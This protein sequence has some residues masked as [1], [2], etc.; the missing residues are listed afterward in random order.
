[1]IPLLR[2]PKTVFTPRGEAVTE[3]YVARPALE[4]AFRRG[5]DSPKNIILHGESGSGKTWLY[6][7]LF[8]TDSVVF[9][10]ANLGRAVPLGSIAALL[11][12]VMAREI[13]QVKTGY[14]TEKETGVDAVIANGRISQTNDFS[15]PQ[16]DVFEQALE[17]I[18]TGAGKKRAALVF[19][20][21]EHILDSEPLL[22]ELSS[23]L[24]L[25]DDENYSKYNVKTVLVSTASNVRSYL[26]NTEKSNTITN[27]I[28]EVPEV[29]RLTQV[30]AR[31]FVKKG[32]FSLLGFTISGSS[33]ADQNSIVEQIIW[34]TDRIPQYL[35]ELCLELAITGESA[36][37]IITDEHLMDA[38]VTWVRSSLISELSVVEANLNS[39]ATTIGRKNQVVYALGQCSELEFDH[40]KIEQ[41]VRREFPESCKS[42]ALNVSQTLAQLAES[43]HPIIRRL[44]YGNGYRFVDPKLRIVVRWKLKKEDNSERLTLRSFDDAI[45]WGNSH[46]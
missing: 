17:W 20:N 4:D 31:E 3:M 33:K 36:G 2:Q 16:R 28:Y 29:A 43:D 26:V 35:H 6:K 18:R 1:M 25:V 24:L 14:S 38:V 46:F 39:K 11:S 44:P 22:R 12:S 7:K 21:L 41:V 10:V 34:Y 30:Q 19:D 9:R 40:A 42:V 5:L 37:R 13:R 23:F 32:L 27:R 8:T 45:R 15:V